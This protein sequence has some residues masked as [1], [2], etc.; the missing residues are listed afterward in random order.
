MKQI[1]HWLLNKLN[2]NFKFDKGVAIRKNVTFYN[3][4]KLLIKK[5]VL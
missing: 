3:N 5:I 2:S 4:G 1:I